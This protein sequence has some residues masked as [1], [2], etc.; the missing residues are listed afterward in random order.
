MT[1]ADTQFFGA[2]GIP[3]FG[4][5][6]VSLISSELGKIVSGKAEYRYVAHYLIP[7]IP[8]RL[9]Q[10]EDMYIYTT[11]LVDPP[12]FWSKWMLLVVVAFGALVFYLGRGNTDGHV[13]AILRTGKSPT[14]SIAQS[15]RVSRPHAAT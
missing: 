6:W 1:N 12:L 11:P 2:H 5:D 4:R 14:H 15:C 3:R 9:Q 10:N 8:V 13:Y 7:G